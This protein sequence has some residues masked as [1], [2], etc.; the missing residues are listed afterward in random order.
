M[1]QIIK[2]TFHWKFITERKSLLWGGGGGVYIIQF[3]ITSVLIKQFVPQNFCLCFTF[4]GI[5]FRGMLHHV[6]DVAYDENMCGPIR[7]SKWRSANWLI[8]YMSQFLAQWELI[9]CKALLIIWLESKHIITAQKMKFPI[10]DFFSK[11]DQIW[12]H[13][14]KKS[15]MENFIFCAVQVRVCACMCVCV[16]VCVCVFK[17]SGWQ[18]KPSVFTIVTLFQSWSLKKNSSQR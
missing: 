14:L 1:Y 3:H 4:T 13:L 11:R 9:V 2:C 6:C 15:L 8:N 10:K 7:T 16:C 18:K 12:S 17:M 5:N